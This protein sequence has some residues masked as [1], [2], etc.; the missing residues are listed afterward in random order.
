MVIPIKKSSMIGN[1]ETE[2]RISFS[3]SL[4]DLCASVFQSL[5]CLLK[6]KQGQRWDFEDLSAPYELAKSNL[7]NFTERK[8]LQK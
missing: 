8:T 4:C 6:S 2:A 5:S 7:A 1:T 3:S